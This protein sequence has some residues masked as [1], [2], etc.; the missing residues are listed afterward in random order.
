MKSTFQTT[1]LL[2]LPL[3]FISGLQAQTAKPELSVRKIAQPKVTKSITQTAGFPTAT[4]AKVALLAPALSQAN[5]FLKPV[6]M[7]LLVLSADGTEP[8]FQ[9]T[10]Y[11]LDYMAIPYDAVVLKTQALPVLN[12][13]TK[14]FYQGIVLSSGNLAL[15]DGVNWSSAL[16]T[17]N[18]T[19]IDT[20]MTT[21]GVR[22]A[23]MY[24]FPEPRYG[25]TMVSA[26][27][28][29]PA[30]PGMV[31]FTAAS[32]TVFSDMNRANAVPGA[33]ASASD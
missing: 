12:D 3:L 2:A 15:F 33:R 14:G 7:K 4:G 17:A 16:S 24:T 20:Y 28:T 9:A 26:V 6:D 13:A 1:A 19:T 23:S 10:K 30:A 11:F 22:A 31:S 8:S 29:T 27:S 21:H 5:L 25:M 32:A 18:W